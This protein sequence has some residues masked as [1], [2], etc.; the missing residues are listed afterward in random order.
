MELSLIWIL[1]ALGLGFGIALVGIAVD[2]ICYHF[3]IKKYF[4][5]EYP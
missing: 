1:L 4:N 3:T 2:S 5:G